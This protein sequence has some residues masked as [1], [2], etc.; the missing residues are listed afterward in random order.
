LKRRGALCDLAVLER[1]MCGALGGVVRRGPLLG[2]GWVPQLAV[3]HQVF[4]AGAGRVRQE[5]GPVGHQV[6]PAGASREHQ[7]ISWAKHQIF[8][9]RASREH[10]EISC[11]R[12]QIFLAGVS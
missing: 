3:T 10:Q 12:H 9:T 2:V 1:E 6:F 11:G 8:L 7:G 4:C 5:A